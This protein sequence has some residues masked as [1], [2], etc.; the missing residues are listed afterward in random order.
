MESLTAVVV[1][2]VAVGDMRDVFDDVSIGVARS[3]DVAVLIK[4]EAAAAIVEL[5]LPS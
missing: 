3:E 2:V 4:D 1:V 5:R